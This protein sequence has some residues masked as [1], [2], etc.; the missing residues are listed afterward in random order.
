MEIDSKMNWNRRPF[1]TETFLIIESTIGFDNA[2]FSLR[3]KEELA[4]IGLEQKEF[5]K[6]MNIE[7]DRMNRL[8]N[9]RVVYTADEIFRICKR[10]GFL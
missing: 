10:L 4:F 6:S 2:D 8:L 1:K 7:P 3:I 9:N 5:A